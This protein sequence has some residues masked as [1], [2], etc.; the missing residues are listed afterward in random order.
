MLRVLHMKY[1]IFFYF[2]PRF[3]RFFSQIRIFPER[4]Q[5]YGDPDPDSEKR[6]IRS[7][8]GEKTGSETLIISLTYLH[9]AGLRGQTLTVI[10]LITLC[11]RTITRRPRNGG[12]DHAVLSLAIHLSYLLFFFTSS[13]QRGRAIRGG[14]SGQG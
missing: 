2:N 10:I 1:N 13:R 14:D 11:R 3:R 5:I 8:S 12:D 4:I 6:L 7:G 9:I